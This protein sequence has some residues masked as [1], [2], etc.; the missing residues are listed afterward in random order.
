MTCAACELKVAKALGAL[1]G[2]QDASASA[3]SGRVT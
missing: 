3:R 2:V 1:P